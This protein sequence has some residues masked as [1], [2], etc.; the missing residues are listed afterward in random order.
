MTTEAI[1]TKK[2]TKCGAELPKTT[3]YFGKKGK[4]LHSYCKRCLCEKQK[5]RYK[6]KRN[7]ILDKKRGLSVRNMGKDKKSNGDE[8]V[9]GIKGLSAFL[10]ISKEVA[11][12]MTNKI[13]HYQIPGSKI[14]LFKKQEVI[15]AIRIDKSNCENIKPKVIEII[16]DN[17]ISVENISG[18]INIR[19]FM[20]MY[21]YKMSSRLYNILMNSMHYI[22]NRYADEIDITELR[23]CGINTESEF[24]SLLNNHLTA[25]EWKR[26]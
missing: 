24:K 10:C 13:P 18:R 20:L 3:E 12:R 9:R 1:P 21:E 6:D 4:Y 26:E 19:Q 8:W 17:K 5:K 16:D 7:E 15:D 11:T 25:T 2:C 23:N 14:I 22:G